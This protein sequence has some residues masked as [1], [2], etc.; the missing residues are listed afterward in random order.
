[1]KKET[2][3]NYYKNGKKVHET[4]YINDKVHGLSIWWYKNGNKYS[5]T[6]FKN[7]IEHGTIIGFN[8]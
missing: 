5:E 6:T 2:K 1:M 7:D 4:P 8:Y 3:T